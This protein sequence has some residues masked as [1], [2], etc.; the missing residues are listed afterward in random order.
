MMRLLRAG[1]HKLVI[2][3]AVI[4]VAIRRNARARR[5]ILRMAH[6]GEGVVLT[7]PPAVSE[8]A[9]L[10]FA[11][12][13][14]GWI[15]SRLGNQRDAVLFRPGEMVPLRGELHEIVHVAAARGVVRPDPEGSRPRLLVYGDAAHLSRRLEDWLKR[16]AKLDLAAASDRFARAMDTR[17]ARLSVRDQKSRWGSCSSNGRLS[18]SWRLI[19]APPF[20][21]DY[22]AAHEVA[23]LIEM[24]HSDRFWTLVERHC[25]RMAEARRWLK[26]HGA[27][28]HRYGA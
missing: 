9:G 13:Q 20:V 15:L 28:L 16:Q 23:H 14:S 6:D 18:Y 26:T 11:A 2:D 24:N 12:R 8:R 1:Y 10:D 27:S 19:L 25:P 7:L 5:M 21:L 17:Y 3:D 22:V 4:P